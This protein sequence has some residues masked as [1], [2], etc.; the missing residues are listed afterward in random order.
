LRLEA[1]ERVEF[2]TADLRLEEEET[3]FMRAGGVKR[4]YDPVQK[5]S[6]AEKVFEEASKRKRSPQIP[7]DETSTQV[8]RDHYLQEIRPFLTEKPA[9]SHAKLFRT[10]ELVV[11]YFTHL[12]TVTQVAA[13]AVL[14]DL[15]EICEE[16]RQ[17]AIQQ[18]LHEWLHGWV[19]VHV[20]LSF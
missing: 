19:Y 11:P 17:L 14:D 15:E 18:R 9:Q 6:A 8:I 2:L 16:R 20:P 10:P 7:V 5:K 12:R 4:H 3:E 13:H 1:D